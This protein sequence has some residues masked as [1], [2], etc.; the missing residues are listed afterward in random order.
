VNLLRLARYIKLRYG[1][2]SHV[3]LAKLVLWRLTRG[4]RRW[5]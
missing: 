2:M 3:Q 1:D 5:Y 4:E